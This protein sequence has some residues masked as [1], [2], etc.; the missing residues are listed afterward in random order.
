MAI[1]LN[2]SQTL[3]YLSVVMYRTYEI[4]CKKHGITNNHMNALLCVMTY[5]IGHDIQ[6][7]HEDDGRFL[8]ILMFCGV[9]GYKRTLRDLARLK[10]LDS[11]LSIG[12]KMFYINAKSL[13]LV[14]D[15]YKTFYK[16]LEMFRKTTEYQSEIEIIPYMVHIDLTRIFGDQFNTGI[17]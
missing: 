14:E 1:K 13:D 17:H 12:R 6:Y 16:R 11:H 5:S 8:D 4:V 7:I 10:Y 2:K 9:R 3:G 15:F